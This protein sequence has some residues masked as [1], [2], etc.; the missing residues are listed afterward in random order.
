MRWHETLKL[1]VHGLY[2]R[3]W[4]NASQFLWYITKMVREY[5]TLCSVSNRVSQSRTHWA[6]TLDRGRC[7]FSMVDTEPW[8]LTISAITVM[9]FVFFK[10][11]LNAALFQASVAETCRPS[12]GFSTMLVRP[13]LNCPFHDFTLLRM[14]IYPHLLSFHQNFVWQF[15]AVDVKA[16]SHFVMRVSLGCDFPSYWMSCLCTKESSNTNTCII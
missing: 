6:D 13:H 15:Y 5:S 7:S 4:T 3:T 2:H 16:W 9:I 12:L 8:L 10:R 11:G 1:D 14:N